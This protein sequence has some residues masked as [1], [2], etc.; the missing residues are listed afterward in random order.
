MEEEKKIR[1]RLTEASSHELN[2]I[3]EDNACVVAATG[4]L[5]IIIKDSF[6][7]ILE[8]NSNEAQTSRHF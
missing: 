8:L 3:E 2:P 1:W 5:E 4:T 7:S 6:L